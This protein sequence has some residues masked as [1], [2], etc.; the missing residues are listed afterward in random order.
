M[1]TE[2]EIDRLDER[3]TRLENHIATKL[4]TIEGEVMKL[5]V[6]L[7]S[8]KECPEPGACMYLRHEINSVAGRVNTQGLEI[9]KLEINQA[10]I[11]GGLSLLATC[12]TLFGPSIRAAFKLP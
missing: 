5:S 9:R 4:T 1:S 7:A 11:F 6:A 8:R 3:V 12:L 2:D 10:W